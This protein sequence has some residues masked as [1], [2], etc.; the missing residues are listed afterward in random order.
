MNDNKQAPNSRTRAEMFKDPCVRVPGL[1]GDGDIKC[2]YFKASIKVRA[3]INPYSV[4]TSRLSSVEF[5]QVDA[6]SKMF[7]EPPL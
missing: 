6:A 4:T 1:Y 7:L 2:A 3:A 5:Y